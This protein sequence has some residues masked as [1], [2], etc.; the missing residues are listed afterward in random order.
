MTITHLQGFQWAHL[1]S[2]QCPATN[3]IRSLP[4]NPHICRDYSDLQSGP[5]PLKPTIPT[6]RVGWVWEQDPS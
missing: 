3:T 2:N 4:H 1:G 6:V 5:D